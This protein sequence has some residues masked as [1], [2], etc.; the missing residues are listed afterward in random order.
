[1]NGSCVAQMHEEDTSMAIDKPRTE[2]DD[3]I[4]SLLVIINKLV[5]LESR[6]DSQS[7]TIE[8]IQDSLRGIID[9]LERSKK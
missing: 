7:S 5:D 9:L 6:M 4:N 2:F 1:M 3:P 8:E